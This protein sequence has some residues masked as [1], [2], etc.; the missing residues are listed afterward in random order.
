MAILKDIKAIKEK[1]DRLTDR[2]IADAEKY[3]ELKKLL[4]NLSV[5][6]KEIRTFIDEYGKIGVKIVYNMPEISIIFDDNN[7]IIKNDTFYAIN[8]L[9]LLSNEDTQKI[10]TVLDRTKQKN[11]LGDLD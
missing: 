4:N 6:V 2:T 3:H 9:G 5:E 10:C 11:I 7:D 1:V 8:M